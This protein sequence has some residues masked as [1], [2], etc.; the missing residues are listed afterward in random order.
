M[1]DVVLQLSSKGKLHLFVEVARKVL[2]A[3]HMNLFV[4]ES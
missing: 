4:T 3:I 2:P 1:C